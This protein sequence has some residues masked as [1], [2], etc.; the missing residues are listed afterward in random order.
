MNPQP[1]GLAIVVGQSHPAA[2]FFGRLALWSFLEFERI[3]LESGVSGTA[4][5]PYAGTP[6]PC[7]Y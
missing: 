7:F 4:A 5:F 3:G 1:E 2:A 6:A